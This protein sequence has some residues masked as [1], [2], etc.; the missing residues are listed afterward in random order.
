MQPTTT[1]TV[2]TTTTTSV[3]PTTTT[4]SVES[5]TTI[6]QDPGGG[7][8]AVAMYGTSAEETRILRNFRDTVLKDMPGGRKVIDMYYE[9]GPDVVS[10][11][12]KNETVK[13]VVRN[14]V[15]GMLPF[16]KAASP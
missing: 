4:T 3:E 15:D 11:M 12:E 7:C 1:T 10:L 16:V 6:P 14:V 9:V 13:A 5:T 2:E 8:P